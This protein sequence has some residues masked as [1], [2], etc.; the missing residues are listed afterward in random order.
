MER[1]DAGFVV[2]SMMALHAEIRSAGV[3]LLPGT[4]SVPAEAGAT[5]ARLIAAPRKNARSE[6][7]ANEGICAE[8]GV[9]HMA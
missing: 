2:W 1:S 5:S 9:P 3:A 4:Q 7:L 6:I 8:K